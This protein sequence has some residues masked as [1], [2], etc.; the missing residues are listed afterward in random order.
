M[1]T[2]GLAQ[3]HLD[4]GLHLSPTPTAVDP[5]KGMADANSGGAGGGAGSRRSGLGRR[6]VVTVVVGGG[7]GWAPTH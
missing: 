1:E 3:L 4:S 5:A 7:R 6:V 2:G